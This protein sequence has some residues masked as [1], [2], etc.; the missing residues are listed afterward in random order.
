MARFQCVCGEQIRTSGGIPNPLEWRLLSDSDFDAFHGLVNAED[1]YAATTIAYRC[2]RSGHL[3]VFWH[4][5]DEN[6]TLYTPS[7]SA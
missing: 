1:V 5:F 3:Y 4:G 7:P 6:P 2:P